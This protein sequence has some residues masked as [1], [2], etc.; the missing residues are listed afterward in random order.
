MTRASSFGLVVAVMIGGTACKAGKATGHLEAKGTL[1]AWT[2]DSGT[3]YS[4]QR[5]Q[6]FGAIAYGPD[7]SG[8]GVK[9]AKDPVKGWTA[10]VNIA[11]TCANEAEKGGCR[12]L[13][14][15]ADV[16][17]TFDIEI[18]NTNTTVNDIVE[19]EGH[20]N[21]DCKTDDYELHGQ[22]ALDSCH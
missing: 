9:V 2:L 14:L 10:I 17:K 20:V 21:L 5:E 1:G 7:K 22:L 3:C 6:Y 19:V 16:C 4:G 11:A 15:T 8:I 18:A 13:I 12:A